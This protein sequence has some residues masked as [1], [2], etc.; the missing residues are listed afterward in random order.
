MKKPKG[1]KFNGVIIGKF[2]TLS[3]LVRYACELVGDNG[4]GMIHIF[5]HKQ[6]AKRKE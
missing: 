6:I 5:S 1:Y 4:A 3:G 2:K